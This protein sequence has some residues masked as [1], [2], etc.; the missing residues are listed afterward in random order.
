M[1]FVPTLLAAL[2]ATVS[3]S[4]HATLLTLDQ[5]RVYSS[6]Y[7]NGG[8]GGGR[9]VGVLFN[10]NFSMSA[11]GIDLNVLS[12][13]Q[14]FKF[15]IY[16]S[17]N[18][19]TAGSLLSSVSFNLN[20]GSGYQNQAF[21]FSFLQGSYYVINF[22][23]SDSAWLGSNLG[24][25]YSWEDPGSFVPHNYGALTVIE[26]FEGAAP[27]N[28]NPLL[29]HMQLVGGGSNNVPEPGSL[30]LLA[31]GLLAAGALRKRAANTQA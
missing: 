14:G 7:D 22:A 9:G 4:S 25:K 12:A 29:P 2:L 27:S 1:K 17:T 19:H 18:G 28:S 16:S 13:Q 8:M 23:R 10:Q 3:L 15:S 11:L 20:A 21:N 31:A 26:G 6:G 5:G 24:T 30:A